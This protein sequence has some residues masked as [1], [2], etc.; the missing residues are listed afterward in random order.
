MRDFIALTKPGV[1]AQVLMT[2]AGGLWLAGG[3]TPGI[4]LACLLGTALIVGAANALNC[5]IERDSDRFMVRTR[6]R[7]LPAGR[8]SAPAGLT[9]GLVLGVAALP[10][11]FGGVNVVT[12]LLGTFSLVTY[13][14]LYTP[15]KRRTA[16]ALSIGAIPGAIPPLLGW[17]AATGTL[18]P[19]GLALFLI[20]FLWQ[21]PH[22][23][24]IAIRREA[25]YTAAGLRTVSGTLGARRTAQLA[26]ISVVLL[27]PASLTLVA[28]GVAGAPF[29]IITSAAGLLWLARSRGSWDMAHTR[30]FFGDSL[31]YLTALFVAL[32]LDAWLR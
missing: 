19:G 12:G 11:L 25:E 18:D 6:T 7:P 13:T 20:L 31:A 23:L 29:G 5:Y 30:R 17:T 28:V 26:R 1:T 4:W 8:L 10:L 16:W 9:F 14:C 32:P 27:L 3:S 21:H 15:L 22:F 24:A 2:T